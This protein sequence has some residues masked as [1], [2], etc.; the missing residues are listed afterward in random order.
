MNPIWG[1]S[2][3]RTTIRS[4][5]LELASVKILC[6]RHTVRTCPVLDDLEWRDTRYSHKQCQLVS[7]FY[8]SSP[9]AC[10]VFRASIRPYVW[11]VMQFSHAAAFSTHTGVINMFILFRAFEKCLKRQANGERVGKN[12][13]LFCLFSI[14]LF[15]LAHLH[16]HQTSNVIA[17]EH[18][19]FFPVYVCF[20]FFQVMLLYICY[21]T[22]ILCDASHI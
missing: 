3:S 11:C 18:I 14:F 20:I 22:T 12:R 2:T 21:P 17:T 19:N 6:G 9:D 16:E 8:S 5:R 13:I 4:W 7:L 1:T 10:N 15:S